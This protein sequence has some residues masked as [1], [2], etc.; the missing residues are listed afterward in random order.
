MTGNDV[1]VILIARE[2][3][4]DELVPAVQRLGGYRAVEIAY[5]DGRSALLQEAI[6]R[7]I[8]SGVRRIM[9]I[10]TLTAGEPG[11]IRSLL[12]REL[13]SQERAH[14]EIEFILVSSPFDSEYH[15]RLLVGALQGCEECDTIAAAVPLSTLSADESCTVHCLRGGHEFVSRLAALGFV[16]GSPVQVVQNFRAGPLIVTVRD[17]RIALGREEARKVRVCPQGAKRRR[18][19][20]HRGRRHGRRRH[21]VPV[22]E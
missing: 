20:S 15:A 16:P 1:G 18:R 17:T 11:R 2:E 3:T 5:L 21:R 4:D 22:E 9:L 19:P 12:M 8:A 10:P 14:P 7:V 13:A 6:D